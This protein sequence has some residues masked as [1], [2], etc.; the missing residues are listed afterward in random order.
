MDVT[1][2]FMSV[3]RIT[4]FRAKDDESVNGLKDLV[5]EGVAV[6]A[7]SAGCQSCQLLQDQDDPKMILVLEVWD[8]VHHRNA[9]ARNIPSDV[10]ARA[11]GLSAG[12]PSGRYFVRVQSD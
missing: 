6:Y 5:L 3:T 8:S 1:E 4:E 2:V 10:V 12:P 11:V 7:V 9:A